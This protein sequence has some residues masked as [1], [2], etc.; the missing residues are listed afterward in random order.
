MDELD[1]LDVYFSNQPAT[2]LVHIL[3]ELPQQD[4]VTRIKLI[5]VLDGDFSPFEI[6]VEPDDSVDTLKR[7]IKKGKEPELDDIAADKL[8]LH[9][10]TIPIRVDEEDLSILLEDYK[11]KAKRIG[12][13]QA[14]TE[15]SAVFGSNP[16]KNTIHVIVQRPS[17]GPATTSTS[18]TS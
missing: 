8:I 15:I 16:A 2:K 17:T 14:V 9:K 5:C 1:T 7:A 6:K 18:S 13:N 3:V 11:D 4:K 10:V 12:S